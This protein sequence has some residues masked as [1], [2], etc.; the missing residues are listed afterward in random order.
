MEHKENIDDF[1]GAGIYAI[2]NYTNGKYYIGKTVNIKNRICSHIGQLKRNKHHCKELQ[3][4]F[5][6]KHDIRFE[7]LEVVEHPKNSA[8]LLFREQYYMEKYNSVHCGYNIFESGKGIALEH[9]LEDNP[10]LKKYVENITVQ[11]D[12]LKQSLYLQKLEKIADKKG[13]S[14]GYLLLST[15]IASNKYELENG[16]FLN[17]FSL[18][19]LEEIAAALGY[20][21]KISFKKINQK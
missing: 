17:N 11:A 20:E 16:S 7:L 3:Q 10:D 9:V 2:H 15:G 5:N 12:V 1:K 21:C 4:D 6:L 14:L 13:L 8:D 19:E 18:N